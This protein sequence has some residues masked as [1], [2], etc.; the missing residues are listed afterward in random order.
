MI[1]HEFPGRRLVVARSTAKRDQGR[2]PAGASRAARRAGQFCTLLPACLLAWALPRPGWAQLVPGQSAFLASPTELPASP[3]PGAGLRSRDPDIRRGVTVTN[4]PRPEYDHPGLRYGPLIVRPILN[5]DGMYDTN[6]LASGRL[7]LSDYVFF[8]NAGLSARTDWST[9]ELRVAGTITDRKYAEYTSQNTTSWRLDASGRYDISR[10][11][12]ID[13]GIGGG[14][15]YVPRSGVESIN[16][17]TPVAG[18][19]QIA[20]LGYAVRE[21]RVGLRLQG[22]YQSLRY[23]PTTIGSPL[24]VQVPLNMAFNNVDNY[25]GAVG[26]AYDLAPLRSAVLITRVNHRQYVEQAANAGQPGGPLDRTSSGYEV[27]GGLNYDFDGIFGIRLLAGWL[28]QFYDDP[29]IPDLS[30][31]TIDA[32]LLWNPTTLTSLRF[33]ANRI[34]TESL[35]IGGSSIVVTRMGGIVDHE[36]A[37]NVLLNGTLAYRIADYEDQRATRYLLLGS[38]GATWLLNR[39]LR[40]GAT[41]IYQHADGGGPA[42]DYD[43]NQFLIRFTAAL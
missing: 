26:L 38:V 22:A 41:Y 29:R 34:V 42:N 43:R 37:R 1:R 32:A 10:F 33:F 21:N 8:A 9:H 2:S 23:M 36:I 17:A 35:S 3:A 25:Y 4:R 20:T 18:D 24:G 11:Q 5:L 40:L 7:P 30:K 19:Q 31:P 15:F 27:L 12:A 6:I 14:R 39:N 13:G 28:Q 16:S